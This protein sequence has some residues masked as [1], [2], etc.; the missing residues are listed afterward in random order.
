MRSVRYILP[1]SAALL[2]GVALW[3]SAPASAQSVVRSHRVPA[4]VERLVNLYGGTDVLPNPAMRAG[5]EDPLGYLLALQRSQWAPAWISST[6][7]DLR[8]V[9]RYR[10][11]PGLHLG[12]D[13][14]LPYGTPVRTGW[15]GQVTAVTPWTNGEYGITILD[16]DGYATTYGHL[17]PIVRV[18]QWVTEEDIIGTVA[19]DHVDIKMRDSLGQYIPF[20]ESSTAVAQPYLHLPQVQ[21]DRKALLTAWLVSQNSVDQMREELFL[22]EN[23]SQKRDLERRSAERTVQSL[24][25]TLERLQEPRQAGLVSHRKMEEFRAELQGAQ[26]KLKELDTAQQGSLSELK[27][28]LQSAEASLSAVSGWAKAQGLA[29]TDV[30]NLVAGLVGEDRELAET[31]IREKQERSVELGQSLTDLE[32]RAETGRDRLQRLEEL[33]LMGGLATREIEDARLRQQ[34]LEEELRLARMKAQ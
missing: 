33:Y 29:W 23:A 2:L 25:A 6:F 10:S 34:L 4:V 1:L 27:R 19:T 31:V 24:Q 32:S 5:R 11:R 30:E 22:R 21:P 9:S 18:G 20:G 15:G 3:L 28:D 8:T 16:R 7:Y 14:A 12:Y 17:T 13:I 26:S